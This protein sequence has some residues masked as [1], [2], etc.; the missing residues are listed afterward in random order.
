M[1][2]ITSYL[3]KT[4]SVDLPLSAFR[5]DRQGWIFQESYRRVGIILGITELLLE[6]MS[7]EI[8]HGAVDC[9]YNGFTTLAL[10]CQKP[11]WAA[12]TNRAWKNAFTKQVEMARSPR[13]LLLSDVL[14][15]DTQYSPDSNAN[16]EQSRVL[17]DVVRWCENL[18][19]LGTLLWM[20]VPFEKWRQRDNPW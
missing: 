10:P 15:H 13:T 11:L 2:E 9:H 19:Q 14:D 1:Q 20:A 5:S 17:H 3:W 18:D 16:D 12:R 7:G 6:G 4:N 8:L